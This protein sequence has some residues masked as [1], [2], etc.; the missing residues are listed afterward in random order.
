MLAERLLLSARALILIGVLMSAARLQG[1]VGSARELSRTLVLPGQEFPYEFSRIS[2]LVPLAD[3]SIIIAEPRERRLRRIADDG[4]SVQTVGR[5][6]AGPGEFRLL[7]Q[8]G[9]FGDTIWATDLGNRRTTF[10]DVEG[11]VLE[12]LVWDVPSDNPMNGGNVILGY[13]SAGTAWGEPRT[14]PAAVGDERAPRE[15]SVLSAD[16]RARIRSLAQVASAHSRFRLLDGATIRS[17]GQPFADAPLVLGRGSLGV[18]IVDRRTGMLTAT[19]VFPVTAISPRGDTLWKREVSFTPRRVAATARD[20]AIS[21][22]QRGTPH[23][24]S[25]VAAALHLPEYRPPASD[26]F[27]SA[28]GAVWI[29]REEDLARVTYVVL[30]SDGTLEGEYVVPRA[31]RLV[32]ARGQNVWAVRTDDDGVP[33]IERYALSNDSRLR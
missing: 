33:S 13:F 27:V 26:A 21:R 6:G 28:E 12:T 11:R 10:F 30:R 8:V 16:G 32:A 25:E 29:R 9:A 4:G 24:R 23:S 1:Q 7:A 18:V 3:G 14:S 31:V 15:L 2:A 17:G 22:I 20:S 5:D 19:K